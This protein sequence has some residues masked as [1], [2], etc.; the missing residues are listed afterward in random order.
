MHVSELPTGLDRLSQQALGNETIHQFFFSVFVKEILLTLYFLSLHLI[1]LWW[2]PRFLCTKL[3]ALRC[4]LFL[5]LLMTCILDT[6]TFQFLLSWHL[7]MIVCWQG[8]SFVVLISKRN[9]FL[10]AQAKLSHLHYLGYIFLQIMQG[11]VFCIKIIAPNL[12][13]VLNVTFLQSL[14]LRDYVS[15]KVSQ[16][17]PSTKF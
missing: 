16:I 15:Q 3:T 13:V 1:L 6:S 8:L 12:L 2:Y 7:N 9:T 11:R 17:T 5:C 4:H 14:T 10:I